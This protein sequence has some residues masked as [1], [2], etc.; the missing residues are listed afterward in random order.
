MPATPSTPALKGETNIEDP[1]RGG[2]AIARRSAEARATVPDVELGMIVDAQ[3]M[4]DLARKGNCS[5]TAVLLRACAVALRESPRVNAAYRD[6]RFELYSR[7]N[8]GVT[9]VTDD[10][11]LTPAV[12][13]ADTKSLGQLSTEIDQLTRRARAGEL[14]PP[15]QAGVTFTLSDLGELGVHRWSQPLLPPQAATLTAGAVRDAAV[16]RHGRL[17]AGRELFIVLACDHRILFGAR[18]ARFLTCVAQLL[19]SPR[20]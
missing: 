7:V 13:D 18:A 8:V 5:H 1:G 11:L 14:T 15:E 3:P 16:V 17:A 12:L 9:V 20:Q 2:Q 6:G 10:G 4:I 19:E